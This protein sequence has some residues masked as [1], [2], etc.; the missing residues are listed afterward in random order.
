MIISLLNII[1]PVFF[2]IGVGF[3]CAKIK[4]INSS[5]VD[6]LL[7]ISQNIFLPLFLFLSVSRI[8]LNHLLDIELLISF[9]V[10]AFSCFI[11]GLLISKVFFKSSNE[12][13]ILIGFCALFSNSVIMGLPIT[14]LAFGKK[15]LE[16][17][18]AI[19]AFHAPFCYILGITFMEV[20][21]QENNTNNEV[22]RKIFKLIF[23]NSL[24][25]GII[26]GFFF[27]FFQINIHI[28]LQKALDMIA[29]AAI[30]LALFALGG[31]L[32][33]Y[34]IYNQFS[35]ILVITMLS[36]IFHPLITLFLSSN[37]FNLK[38]EYV[39]SAVITASMAPGI[40]AF[41]FSSMYNNSKDISAGAVLICTPLTI[42]STSFWIFI[43]NNLNQ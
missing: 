22:T 36:L 15:A 25:I 39:R 8:D 13:A 17:N 20:F 7:K 41:L 26:L 24:T 18:F 33:R 30:P 6:Q 10:G 31:V 35:K 34:K 2:I 12:Q 23:S 5:G 9:Y 4:L 21:K 16:G 28:S 40:N 43:L 3:F 29:I 19:I 1:L 42:F 37:I 11:L 27:N 14:E 32:I 38:I